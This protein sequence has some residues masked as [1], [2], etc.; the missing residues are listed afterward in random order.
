MDLRK[1]Y[2]TKKPSRR[3][4]TLND[5]KARAI[6]AVSRRASDVANHQTT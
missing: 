5:D 4:P 3:C 6:A 2:G 1:M